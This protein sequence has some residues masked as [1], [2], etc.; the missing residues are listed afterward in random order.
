MPVPIIAAAASTGSTVAAITF[1]AATAVAI[2]G[3]FLAFCRD[4][5]R[6]PASRT[7]EEQMATARQQDMESVL[8]DVAAHYKASADKI[9]QATATM[10]ESATVLGDASKDLA[11]TGTTLKETVQLAESVQA[12]MTANTIPKLEQSYAD[13]H[14]QLAEVTMRLGEFAEQI[15]KQEEEINEATVQIAGLRETVQLQ[16]ETITQLEGTLQQQ[17]ELIGK[18]REEIAG[19]ETRALRLA[20]HVKFFKE[21]AL[22]AREALRPLAN[23]AT[24]I[25]V[26]TPDPQLTAQTITFQ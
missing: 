8:R 17:T 18:Q 12:D 9:N 23:K 16:A 13:A 15:G 25:E 7:R 26:P 24:P 2:A 4:D 10:T 11:S 21:E 19:H 22:K 6:K 5:D 20:K 1:T 14:Q 3:N